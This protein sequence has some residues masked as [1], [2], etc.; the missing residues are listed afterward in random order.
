MY[1]YIIIQIRN[2]VY[3]I[4]FLY[5]VNTNAQQNTYV[6]YIKHYSIYGIT[7][8]NGYFHELGFHEI[9][10]TL[11]NQK[12]PMN[13]TLLILLLLM[14]AI[15]FISNISIHKFSCSLYSNDINT[16]F[17]QYMYIHYI[18]Y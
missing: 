6:C 3:Y 11:D 10:M 18:R 15:L 14:I 7:M 17:I 12:I 8:C 9:L 5:I 1:I 16:I 2:K 4:D 13:K